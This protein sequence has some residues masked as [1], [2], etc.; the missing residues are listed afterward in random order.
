MQSLSAAG[1]K[2]IPNNYSTEEINYL[3]EKKIINGY[4][5]GKFKP[6]NS[7]TRAEAMKMV[8]TALN[9]DGNKVKSTF[10]DVEFESFASGY[11]ES[12]YKKGIIGGYPDGTFKPHQ[13]ITR[14]EM[15]IVISKA[16]N[17]TNKSHVNFKD[18]DKNHPNYE[19]IDKI[20][21]AGITK[22]YPNG[23]YKPKSFITRAEFSV[24]VAR[25]L[26]PSF[27]EETNDDTTAAKPVKPS[28]KFVR[29]NTTLNVRKGPGTN[30]E[31]VGSLR[32]GDK[33][34]A[35]STE[36][37]WVKITKGKLSGY[38]H[39][40]YLVDELDRLIV[41]DPGHGGKDSGASANN[42][43]EK[44]VN[45]EVSKYL[46][47]YLEKKDIQVLMTRETDKYLSL[48]ERVD[49]AVNNKADTFVSIHANSATPSASG[50]ATYYYHSRARMDSRTEASR[51]L[52]AFIQ[53]EL[54][55]ATG[56]RDRGVKQ[57]G[58]RVIKTNPLPSTL[59]ELGFLTNKSDAKILKEK[60]QVL[61]KAISEGIIS[62]YNWKEK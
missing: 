17:I 2:D 60:K 31:R 61:A 25:A 27:I 8:G 15:A 23:T 56:M 3:I 49:F 47:I 11:I 37:Q 6:D 22:G 28:V 53:D 5:D 35:H 50:V 7:V 54:V 9:L 52:S 55:E 12:A 45:L 34:T 43:R 39:Q 57:A 29:V 24:M 4:P 32:N 19:S 41:I 14:G 33:V 59:V 26:D 46:K 13:S 18:V 42:L 44:D 16:F 40:D 62:Y 10:P 51:V 21:T 58:F 38:V 48:D 36:G 1:L 30:Y 20:F